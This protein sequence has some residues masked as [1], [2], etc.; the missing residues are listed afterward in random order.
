VPQKRNDLHFL[1]TSVYRRTPVFNSEFFKCKF[2]ATPAE[3]RGGL[4]PP[5]GAQSAPLLSN[6]G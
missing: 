1:T 2:I 6:K 3:R 5:A 4:R